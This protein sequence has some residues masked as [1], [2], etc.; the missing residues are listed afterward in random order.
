MTIDV[1]RTDGDRRRWN[2]GVERSPLATVFH[3]FEA[4][5]VMAEFSG[6]TATPL[7]GYESGELVG[8]FPVFELSKGPVTAVFSPPPHLWVQK[9]GPAFPRA[10]GLDRR[11]VERRRHGFIDGVFEWL[12]AHRNPGFVRVLTSHRLDD[13]R[14]FAWNACDLTPEYTYV[15]DLRVGA[16]ALLEQFSS[17]ARRNIK[18]G[19]EG[20]YDIG[21]GD[22]DDVIRL[23]EQ[24][25]RR[26]EEQDEPFPVPPEF[27]RVL[28]D[29]APEG[30]IRP[31]VFR[32]G[33]DVIGGIIT[34]DDGTTVG[35]WYGG[36]TP[37]VD[38]G[39]AVNDL[40]DWHV[41]RDAVDRGRSFYD[42]VGAGDPRLNRYKAKFSPR[43]GTFYRAERVSVPV[44]WLLRAYRSIRDR[45][46][47]WSPV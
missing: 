20:D 5:D 47:G 42:F 45:D 3:R 33:G 1:R 32:H 15:V 29:R 44:R 13:P 22:G 12:G 19:D 30:T 7:V 39:V 26:Y 9:L 8:L 6:T 43:L 27:P 24:V 31:Y 16:D 21:A 14:P 28:Y 34:Y 4:M 37:D 36:V 25:I 10:D 40:L 41:M 2:R 18:R 17:D 46:P 11:A 38:V 23:M 35:R